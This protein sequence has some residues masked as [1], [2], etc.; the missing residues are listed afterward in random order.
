YVA[1]SVGPYFGSVS[2]VSTGLIASTVSH[3]ISAAETAVS[4]SSYTETAF[5]SRLGVGA[6]I[7]LGRRFTLGFGVGYC[8]VTDFERRIGSETNYSGPDVALSFG[9]L[10]GGGK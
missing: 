6:D 10:L 8:L 4:M 7:L 2:G 9:I 1:A 5:G 3:S